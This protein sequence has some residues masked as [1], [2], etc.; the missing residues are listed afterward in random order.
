MTTP[1]V[2][3]LVPATHVFTAGGTGCKEVVD[4]RDKVPARGLCAFAAMTVE[5]G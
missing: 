4:A 1:A 3:G 5:V 2:A